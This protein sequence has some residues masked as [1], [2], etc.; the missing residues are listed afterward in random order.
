MGRLGPSWDCLGAV[1]GSFWVRPGLYWGGLGLSWGCLGAI[2]RL[3]WALGLSCTFRSRL[4][5]QITPEGVP[6]GCVMKGGG[7]AAGRTRGHYL[8]IY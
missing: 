5:L 1:L 4:G 6:G 3:P 8:F 7:G 2:L